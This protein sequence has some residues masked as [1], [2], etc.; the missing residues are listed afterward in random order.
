MVRLSWISWLLVA[1]AVESPVGLGI[2][3]SR[4][5]RSSLRGLSFCNGMDE[6]LRYLYFSV[7]VVV[8]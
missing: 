5:V 4:C 8:C 1:I 7:G 6:T 2:Y 3:H